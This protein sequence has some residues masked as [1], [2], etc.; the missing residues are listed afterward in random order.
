MRCVLQA[1][2]PLSPDA[3]GRGPWSAS[4]P[5]RKG[6]GMHSAHS[7]AHTPRGRRDQS[8]TAEAAQ[9]EAYFSDL[10]SYRSVS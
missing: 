9:A 2:A 10:L 5:Q 7:G 3:K 1:S 6:S 4:S 8:A